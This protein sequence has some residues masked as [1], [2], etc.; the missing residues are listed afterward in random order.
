MW[1][2][3]P[4]VPTMLVAPPTALHINAGFDL[5]RKRHVPRPRRSGVHGL[6]EASGRSLYEGHEFSTAGEALRGR[7]VGN[8]K[9]SLRRLSTSRARPPAL[10]G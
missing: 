8:S 1:P 9:A 3:V 5:R 4:V 10:D 2:G 6:N 7:G